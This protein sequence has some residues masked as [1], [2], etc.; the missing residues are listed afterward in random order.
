M[1]AEAHNLD[2][3]QGLNAAFMRNHRGQ[4]C[5]AF[6]DPAYARAEAIFVDQDSHAIYAII[7]QAAHLVGTVSEGMVDAFAGSKEA[8]LTAL[9][10]D[11]S[12]LEL[13]APVQVG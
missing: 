12:V 13:S 5:I 6:A 9:R 3:L 10:P 4:V 2:S 8:L 11:G 1:L 7:H